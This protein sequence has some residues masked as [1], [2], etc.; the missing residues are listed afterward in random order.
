MHTITDTMPVVYKYTLGDE[1]S[2]LALPIGARFLS[3]HLQPDPEAERVALV[4]WFI[5]IPANAKE[6]RTFRFFSTGAAIPFKP[7]RLKFLHTVAQLGVPYVY[8]L[9]EIVPEVAVA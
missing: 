8:H 2:A 3:A 9:F 7:D 5:V 1:V 4:A 6:I